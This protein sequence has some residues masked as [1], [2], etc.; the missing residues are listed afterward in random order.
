MSNMPPMPACKPAKLSWDE[1]RKSRFHADTFF[2]VVT[3]EGE[4]VDSAIQFHVAMD[5]AAQHEGGGNEASMTLLLM[6]M[7]KLTVSI[8]HSSLLEKMYEA[9]LLK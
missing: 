8:V 5:F 3:S 1:F 4:W 9:G 6:N 7:T 2:G